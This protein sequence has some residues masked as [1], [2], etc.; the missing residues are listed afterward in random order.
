MKTSRPP[1]I[2]AI[3][4]LVLPVLYVGSYLALVV[5]E[6]LHWTLF[7]IVLAH[8]SA[9]GS[10]GPW[11]KSTGGLGDVGAVEL[12]M[13]LALLLLL[14]ADVETLS[15]NLGVRSVEQILPGEP[16]VE[17]DEELT[18]TGPNNGPRSAW[19]SSWPISP[20]SS[21]RPEHIWIIY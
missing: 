9:V 4:L 14:T 19:R 13:I 17:G 2:V 21:A 10:F 8:L 3:V 15:A 18:P 6:L 11:S 20:R 1:L 5:P 7:T 12:P 16:A